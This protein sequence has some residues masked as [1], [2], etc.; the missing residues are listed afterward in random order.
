MD[1]H[2]KSCWS[3]APP[4]L[5]KFFLN[6]R[7][8]ALPHDNALNLAVWVLEPLT[9]NA[10]T[11]EQVIE[12]RIPKVGRYAIQVRGKA[13]E[14]ITAVGEASL[15]GHRKKGEVKPRLFMETLEGVGRTVW[16]SYPTQAG[17]TGMPADARRVISVGAADAKAR[18]NHR[19]RKGLRPAWL[20]WPDQACWHLTRGAGDESI[21][22]CHHDES[23]RTPR[24]NAYESE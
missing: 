9:L 17:S 10:G 2:L 6:W 18:P 12:F 22:L 11:Y 16:A 21:G 13:P 14:G 5:Q 1:T 4:R 8:L 15:P 24:S 7:K 19:P 20:C 3:L 23:A